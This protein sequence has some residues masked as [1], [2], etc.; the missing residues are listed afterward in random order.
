MPFF[1]P[2]KIGI[3]R[4][5]IVGPDNENGA[6]FEASKEIPLGENTFLSPE[7]GLSYT[8]TFGERFAVSAV[9]MVRYSDKIIAFGDYRIIGDNDQLFGFFE[10]DLFS[11]NLG[12]EMAYCFK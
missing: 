7:G 11:L 10:Q 8:Y 9:A 1:L 4:S 2:A 12:I 5:H 3:G 6:Y